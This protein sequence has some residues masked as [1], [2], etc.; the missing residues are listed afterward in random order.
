MAIFKL[1]RKI[2]KNLPGIVLVEVLVAMGVMAV[3]LPALVTAY[4]AARGGQTSAVERF[5]A[6]MA[7]EEA[8]EAVRAVRDRGWEELMTYSDGIEYYPVVQDDL[9]HLTPGEELVDSLAEIYRKIEFSPLYRDADGKLTDESAGNVLDPSARKVKVTIT[10]Q[11]VPPKILENVFYVMRFENLIWEQT[12]AGEFALGIMLGTV[13]TNIGG[14]EIILGSGG[15]GNSDWCDPSLALAQY[16]LPKSGVAN[17]IAAIPAGGANGHIIAGTGDNAAGVSLADVEVTNTN[18]PSLIS[19]GTLDG[20]KT[21]GVFVDDNYAYL[22]TDT[23][24]S[25][26]VIVELDSFVQVGYFDAPGPADGT[27][28]A[29][30]GSVGFVIAGNSLYSFSLN[31]LGMGASATQLG[32]VALTGTGTEMTVVGNYI[33]IAESTGGRPLEIV[34][35]DG[36]GANLQVVGWAAIA[37]QNGAAVAV[38]TSATRA[39]L[40]TVQGNVYILDISSKSG[41]LPGAIGSYNTG[42]L[43]PK[44]ITVVTNNKAIVVG[45]GGSLQYQVIELENENFPSLCDRG[46]TTSGGLAV[47]SGINDIASVHEADGD[48]YSYIITGDTG[49]EL[50]VIQGGGGQAGGAY[51]SDGT[52]ETQILDAGHSVFFNRFEVTASTPVDTTMVYQ[53]AIAEPVA[54][55]CESAIYNYVGP[56]RTSATTFGGGGQFPLGTSTGYS[57]P[58]QCLRMKAILHTEN[59]NNTP[60]LY[61]ISV[62]YSP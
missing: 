59:E 44:G 62:S 13:T 53:V 21:N 41:Q 38:N 8:Q 22:S 23:N 27:A 40:A 33:Y 57:N 48:T 50:K 12:T 32:S 3:M 1:N 4:F 30:S 15:A 56:D 58:G 29:S 24:S 11:T 60:T 46:G 2:I 19:G 42:G 14:G 25:E 54:G 28:V 35:F 55:S 45:T 52:F 47:V 36:T 20:F 31:N 16:D 34:Q 37:G 5:R 39:Y 6:T 18:P 61:D 51:T 26:V 9:W 49:A 17:A 7:A 10:T 43:S